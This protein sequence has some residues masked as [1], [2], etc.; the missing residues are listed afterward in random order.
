[1]SAIPPPPPAVA[2][3][4]VPV[5]TGPVGATLRVRCLN[6]AHAT[7]GASSLGVDP[8]LNPERVSKG[9]T[10]EGEYIVATFQAQDVRSL[11]LSVSAYLDMVGV[12]LRTLRDFG[13]T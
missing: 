8:E 13:D 6:A 4:P 5:V 7:I 9:T 11:R 10:T 12:V 3:S 2:L 1:M